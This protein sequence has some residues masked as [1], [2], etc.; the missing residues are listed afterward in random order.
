V[1]QA[2][3]SESHPVAVSLVGSSQKAKSKPSITLRLQTEV[4]VSPD[5]R[6]SRPAQRTVPDRLGLATQPWMAIAGVDP[7]TPGTSVWSRSVML[8]FDF[9]F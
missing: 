9:A 7:V 3:T 5:R 1:P 2:D 4:R 6:Q 8:G